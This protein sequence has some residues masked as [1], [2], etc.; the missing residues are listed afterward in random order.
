MEEH[1]REMR[2]KLKDTLHIAERRRRGDKRTKSTG[3]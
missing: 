1:F 3:G 2:C